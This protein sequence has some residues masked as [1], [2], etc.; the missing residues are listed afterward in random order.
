MQMRSLVTGCQ[1]YRPRSTGLS[2]GDTDYR[3]AAN[4]R[5]F[6]CASRDETR[7]Q[8]T[9]LRMTRFWWMGMSTQSQSLTADSSAALRNDKQKD[10]QRQV[11][12]RVLHH[13]RLFRDTRMTKSFR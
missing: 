5:S 2:E 9:P 3:P 4:R 13:C 11:Q 1:A 8:E 12:P 10:R 6:D 7:L